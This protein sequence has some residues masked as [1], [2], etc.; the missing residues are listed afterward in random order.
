MKLS[1]T[2][3]CSIKFIQLVSGADTAAELEIL[4]GFKHVQELNSTNSLPTT[5]TMTTSSDAQ[6]TPIHIRRKLSMARFGPSQSMATTRELVTAIPTDVATATAAASIAAATAYTAAAAASTVAATAAHPG[7]AADVATTAPT[8][9]CSGATADDTVTKD[10][11]AATYLFYADLSSGEVRCLND[12]NEPNYMVAD[13]NDYLHSTLASCCTTFFNWDYDTCMEN[14][15]SIRARDD[16]RATLT[17]SANSGLYYPD[18]NSFD[19]VCKN[20]GSQPNYMNDIPHV[21]MHE[22]LAEC[23]TRNFG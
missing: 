6:S 12:G 4:S 1:I 18:W 17:S 15:P 23:C 9:T 14:V 7:T 11:V 13:T 16:A 2:L 20:D 8:A 5:T 19:H 10:A 3:T 22:D 21:W